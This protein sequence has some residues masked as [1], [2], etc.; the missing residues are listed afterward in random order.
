MTSESAGQHQAPPVRGRDAAAGRLASAAGILAR[1]APRPL[2]DR[3]FRGYWGAHT[4]SMFGDE[5]TSV[6]LPLTA[7]LLL[8]AG[9]AQMGALTALTW[10][11]SL[12]F[13][14]H[15]GAWADRRGHRRATMIVCDLGCCALLASIPAGYALGLLTLG[16]LYLVAF[17]VGTFATLFSVCDSAL[18]VALVPSEQVVSGQ[19]LVQGS[20]ALS[21][22]GGPA[23]AGLLV[24]TFSAPLAI[25]ADAASFLGSAS[26]L[27]RIHPSEPAAQPAQRGSLAAGARFIRRTPTVRAALVAVATV[28]FFN[29]VFF[30]LFLLYLIRDLH[31]RP[32][33]LG[34]LFS[35]GAVGGVIG[36]LAAAGITRRAGVG[37]AYLIGCIVF[38]A[39]LIL[40]PLAAGPPAVILALLFLAVFA[41]GF[42]V[43]ILDISSGALFAA[44]V[45]DAL[46]SRVTGAFQTVNFGTR[47]LGSLLGG[48]LGTLIGL[49]PTLWIA[50]IGGALG[51]L[52]LLPSPLPRFRAPTAQNTNGTPHT[53]TRHD[54]E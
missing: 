13:A 10:L 7:V 45:P 24:Q 42:G 54:P 17:G 49:H 44:V 40:V 5:I 3:Q 2:R 28:N 35:A 27:G 46:R 20:R 30:A 41:S 6:A 18:F 37:R 11:P 23:L 52:W 51:F 38:P 25:A 26:L 12:L 33:P 29:F 50:A 1:R 14:L 48:A 15:A 32:G 47:P 43:M 9:P 19:S 39:P 8:H 22:V 16:Q 53:P 4:I 31:V 21:F 36:A 34:L